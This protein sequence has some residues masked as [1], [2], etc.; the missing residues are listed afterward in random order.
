MSKRTAKTLE[1]VQRENDAY[2]LPDK[3]DLTKLRRTGRNGRLLPQPP[4]E[5]GKIRITIRIDEDIYDWFGEQ[6]DKHEGR[7][8]YQTLLNNALREY[9]EGKAPKFE[10]TLRRIIREELQATAKGPGK[11]R[12]FRL[13]R[14]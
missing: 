11:S 2:E 14:R 9:I 10:G 6:A 1:Q 12:S 8:G 4:V 7:V 13:G 5:P 3:L